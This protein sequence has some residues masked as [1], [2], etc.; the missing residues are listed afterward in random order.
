[1]P[2]LNKSSIFFYTVGSLLVLS[3]SCRS[4][5][6]EEYHESE[7]Y[8]TQ[9]IIVSA[10]V[11]ST[12]LD[13]PFMKEIEYEYFINDSL[14]LTNTEDLLYMDLEEGIPIEVLVNKENQAISFYWRNGFTDSITPYQVQYIEAKLNEVV[15][16]IEN[17]MNNR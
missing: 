6:F 12:I 14:I 9:G 2:M 10:N 17:S 15:F 3:I 8:K 1:M 4:K 13:N 7:F 16:E 5:S 11:T